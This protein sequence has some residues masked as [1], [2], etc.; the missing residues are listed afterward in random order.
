MIKED[1][2]FLTNYVFNGLE[3]YN[4][5]DYKVA[6]EINPNITM[7]YYKCVISKEYWKDFKTTKELLKIILKLLN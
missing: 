5:K 7:A 1:F 6:I 4:L 3:N 2:A